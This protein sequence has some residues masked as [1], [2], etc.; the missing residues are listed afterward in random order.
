MAAYP[1]R[2]LPVAGRPPVLL[3]LLVLAAP[4]AGAS[5][6]GAG[7]LPRHGVEP[8]AAARSSW[9]W[10]PRSASTCP[11][12]GLAAGG[13]RARDAARYGCLLRGHGVGY[14]AL[15][16]ALLQK[17]GLFLGHPNYALSVVLAALLLATR[18]RARCWSGGHRAGGWA[19]SCAS[20]ATP[21]RRSCSSSTSALLPLLHG[22]LGLPF[23]ARALVAVLLVAPIGCLLGVV[24]AHGARAPEAGR[25][26]LRP[27][28]LGHQR[29]VLGAGAAAE[30]RG[31]DDLGHLR[32]AAGRDTGLPDGG[33]GRTPRPRPSLR[34]PPPP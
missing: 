32:P 16:I 27:L 21:W 12:A 25:P 10:P 24:R 6:P 20:S 2:H 18:H 1:V 19:A 31:V 3:P 29:H 22:L 26:G 17:F 4:V 13:L 33:L 9:A 28:G 34:A 30:R 5:R 14:M 15:E 8:G 7:N 23:P 11:C